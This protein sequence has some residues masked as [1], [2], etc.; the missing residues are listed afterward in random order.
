MYITHT[1]HTYD[2]VEVAY[3]YHQWWWEVDLAMLSKTSSSSVVSISAVERE[4][5]GTAVV[6]SM[7]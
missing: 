6:L 1:K 3:T 2:T 4:G 5:L 7:Q